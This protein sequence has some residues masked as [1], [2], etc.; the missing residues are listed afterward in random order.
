MLIYSDVKLFKRQTETTKRLKVKVKM[1]L[2]F[3]KSEQR[4]SKHY[5]TVLEDVVGSHRTHDIHS[6]TP[7]NTLNQCGDWKRERITTAPA[8]SWSLRRLLSA[9]KKYNHRHFTGFSPFQYEHLA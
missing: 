3:A 2:E 9:K 4:Y 7:D 8:Y 5:H 1:P 6:P